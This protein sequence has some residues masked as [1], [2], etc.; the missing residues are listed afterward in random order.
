MNSGYVG[1][2]RSLRSQS[3]IESYEMPLSMIKKTEIENFL[4]D[5]E[6]EFNEND[7]KFLEK[8]SVAKWKY[9]AKEHTGISS[10]HHT[11]SYFNET[12]HYD[13]LSVAE[14]AIELKEEI[15]K[16]YKDYQREKN[17]VDVSFGIMEVEVWGGS[18]KHPKLEGYE[19]LAGIIIGDWLYSKTDHDKNGN[20]NRNKINANKVVWLKEYDNYDELI[21]KHRDFKNTKR[22]FNNL[23]KEKVKK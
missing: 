11:S 12:N 23:I 8:L 2:S 21:K 19:V 6:E 18:R 15:D 20:T 1:Y 17:D 16:L 7:F 14:K 9:V 3:A 10:W 22:V 5:Y 4:S 13:L